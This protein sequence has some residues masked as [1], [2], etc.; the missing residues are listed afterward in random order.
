MVLPERSP[1]V[2]VGTGT[3]TVDHLVNWAVD[4]LKRPKDNLSYGLEA[5]RVVY[6][7]HSIL[8]FLKV[9]VSDITAP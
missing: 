6:V 5:V 7:H 2:V 4:C 9:K 3:V 8:L 1:L